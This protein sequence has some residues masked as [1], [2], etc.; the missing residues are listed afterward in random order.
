M[1]DFFMETIVENKQIV[2]GF[3]KFA[4]RLYGTFDRTK[5][6]F[7]SPHSV[8]SALSLAYLGARG[9]TANQMAL[10]LGYPTSPD[11]IVKAIMDLASTGCTDINLASANSAWLQNGYEILSDYRQKLG[12]FVR[13][14]DFANPET[15]RQKINKWVEENTNNLIKDLIP[16]DSLTRVVLANAIHFKAPW[17]RPFEAGITRKAD[18]Y[19]LDGTTSSVDMMVSNDVR[20]PYGSNGDYEAVRLPYADGSMDMLVIVP[21]DFKNFSDS[22]DDNKLAYVYNS[23][24]KR[25]ID[26]R[27]PKFKLEST[28]TLNDSMRSLGMVDAFELPRADFSGISGKRDLFI[29][30]IL[31]KAVVDVYEEGTEA[32]AAMVMRCLCFKETPRMVV[33]RPFIFAICLND[34]TPIFIGQMVLP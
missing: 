28:L 21:R 34:G 31:H 3:C 5:N 26:L 4:L 18:F 32:A 15:A 6:L 29:S 17:S 27:F 20:V 33:N 7:F 23:L 30:A 16:S 1:L 10:A 19:A 8:S 25:E 11:G 9:E 14:V 24:S 12:D 22:F 2:E 13:E